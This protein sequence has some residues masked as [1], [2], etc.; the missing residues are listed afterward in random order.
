MER[1]DPAAQGEAET[2]GLKDAV[3]PGEADPIIGMIKV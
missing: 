2:H 3:N 1:G